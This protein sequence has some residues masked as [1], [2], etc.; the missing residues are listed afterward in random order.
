MYAYTRISECPIKFHYWR[1]MVR[2]ID[3]TE[4]YSRERFLVYTF[5]VCPRERK[6][7]AKEEADNTIIESRT[8]LPCLL[9]SSQCVSP[10]SLSLFSFSFSLSLT[11]FLSFKLPSFLAFLSLYLV[12][13]RRYIPVTRSDNNA[14]LSPLFQNSLLGVEALCT[15]HLY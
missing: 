5:S 11:F 6:R 9:T 3:I 2:R 13:S 1:L 8:T 7:R 12:L 10:F 14:L 4:N 15:R